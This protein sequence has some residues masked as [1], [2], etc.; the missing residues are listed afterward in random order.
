M[1]YQQNPVFVVVILSIGLGGY[2]L[3]KRKGSSNG[4][5]KTGFFKGNQPQANNN[6]GD[7]VTLMMLQQMFSQ[8]ENS[9]PH[10]SDDEH[11]IAIEQT[12]KEILELLDED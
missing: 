8:Q 12:Q 10:E 1:Y 4:N 9:I 3:F 7:L 6:M 11:K 5:M 2:L